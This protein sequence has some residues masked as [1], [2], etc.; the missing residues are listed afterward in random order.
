[1]I[2]LLDDGYLVAGQDFV[3]LKLDKKGNKIWQKRIIKDAS[4]TALS[5]IKLNNDDFLISGYSTISNSTS[6]GGFIAEFDMNGS[7]I[8]DHFYGVIRIDSV[9][10]ISDEGFLVRANDFGD[11]ITQPM[12]VKINKTGNLVW[13]YTDRNKIREIYNFREISESRYNLI[14]V[15]NVTG[16]DG[17]EVLGLAVIN[18]SDDG[19]TIDKT[20]LIEQ[21]GVTRA[22]T[23]KGG[24]VTATV[25]YFDY[26]ELDLVKYDPRGVMMWNTTIDLP[27]A[28]E[29]KVSSILQTGDGGYAVL[30]YNENLYERK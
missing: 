7:T 15:E 23:L 17:R 9:V 14:C 27:H 30:G 10:Q 3:I 12:L 2:E 26:P 6:K 8:W 20:I 11:G 28:Y 13:S 5:L 19:R 22:L 29:Y 18:L 25:P 16:V 1:V 24:Y 21:Y 4:G